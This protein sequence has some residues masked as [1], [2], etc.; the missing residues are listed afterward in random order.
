MNHALTKP[1]VVAPAKDRFASALLSQL[2]D[3]T[4]QA[5]SLIGVGGLIQSAPTITVTARFHPVDGTGA[6]QTIKLPSG[7]GGDIWL[8]PLGLWTLVTGGNIRLASAAVV[9]RAL[10]LIWDGALWWPAY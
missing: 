1:F 9:G 2:N 3:L 5:N 6:I 10:A 7:A 8:L 4:D